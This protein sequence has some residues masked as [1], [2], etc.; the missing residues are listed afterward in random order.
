[1]KITDSGRVNGQTECLPNSDETEPLFTY[2][3]IIV[4]TKNPFGIN[5]SNLNTIRLANYILMRQFVIRIKSPPQRVN[6]LKF[7]IDKL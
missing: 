7:S 6:P 4:N 1:M 3:K 2:P 5:Q